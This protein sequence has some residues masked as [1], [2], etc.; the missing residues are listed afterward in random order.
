M[1][2]LQMVDPPAAEAVTAHYAKG[3]ELADGSVAGL[4][5]SLLIEVAARTRPGSPTGP[6]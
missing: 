4:D 5:A 1:T 2:A 3:V 6:S